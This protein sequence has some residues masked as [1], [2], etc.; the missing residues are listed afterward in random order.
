[1][2]R[3]LANS[4]NCRR[5]ATL[6]LENP[7]PMGVVTGPLR[8]SPV[9]SM[10]CVSSL[11]MY[12]PYLAKASDPAAK[13]SHSIFTPDASTMRTAAL[14]TSGPIP[15]P[16]IRVTLCAING[17]LKLLLISRSSL[18]RA[19]SC[20]DGLC[21]VFF[22]VEQRLQLRMEFAHILEISV[23]GGEAYVSDL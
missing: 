8:P 12:S 3:K 23:D 11:G 21:F 5:N 1:M 7:P 15:S 19:G 22:A 2:G 17:V 20:F 9:L 13:L 4:S 10:E 16:G 18:F 14:V 6:M